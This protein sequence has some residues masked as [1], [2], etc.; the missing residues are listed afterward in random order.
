M[1][2]FNAWLPDKSTPGTIRTR[3]VV[4]RG[5]ELRAWANRKG[6]YHVDLV[7]LPDQ[8]FG[9]GGGRAGKSTQRA[10]AAEA[11]DMMR[12]EL[13]DNRDLERFIRRL[14]RR[15]REAKR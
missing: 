8:V 2:A 4:R 1:I 9:L 13:T 3:Y 10:G 15:G 14:Q 7:V 5:I 6:Q 11:E 12:R